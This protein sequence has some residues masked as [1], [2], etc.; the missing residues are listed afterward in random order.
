MKMRKKV[1]II[2]KKIIGMIPFALHQ[3]VT[4]DL[5]LTPHLLAHFLF[6][7]L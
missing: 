5:K 7:L 1:K 2:E 3:M 4:L 6:L